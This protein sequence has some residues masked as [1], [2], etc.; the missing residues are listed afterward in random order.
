M[1]VR[2]ELEARNP[3]SQL[4]SREGKPKSLASPDARL[5]DRGRWGCHK[6]P[7][8][9]VP[10]HPHIY[11]LHGRVS[12]QPRLRLEEIAGCP[13]GLLGFV[14]D[15]L[16][17]SAL[18]LP[19]GCVDNPGLQQWVHLHHHPP[20]PPLHT[21]LPPQIAEIEQNFKCFCNIS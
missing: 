13:S 1:A 8:M 17:H 14:Q 3:A 12:V 2:P 4:T 10:V 16:S 5:G 11:G 15:F 20:Q 7:E 19:W 6:S 18:P 21:T 9:S